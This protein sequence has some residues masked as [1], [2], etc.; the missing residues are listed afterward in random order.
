[1][2]TAAGTEIP[3]PVKQVHHRPGRSGLIP[4]VALFDDLGQDLPIKR[5]IV[6]PS[7]NQDAHFEEVRKLV[8]RRGIQVQKSETP[9]VGFA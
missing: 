4:Y 3:K 7:R 6:G 9:Y 1:M 5:I 2:V 8:N